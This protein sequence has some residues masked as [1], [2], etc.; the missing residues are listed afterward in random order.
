MPNRCHLA[1]LQKSSPLR[2]KVR[3]DPQDEFPKIWKLLPNFWKFGGEY[4][5]PLALEESRLIRFCP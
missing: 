2:V 5:E 3:F 4:F 1:K